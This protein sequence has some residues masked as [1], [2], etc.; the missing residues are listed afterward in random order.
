MNELQKAYDPVI[1]KGAGH[2][3]MKSGEDPANKGSDNA[4]ARNDA[5]ERW[6][7]ILKKI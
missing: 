1:Y 7:T 4:T 5:W 3:F 6:K 2:G